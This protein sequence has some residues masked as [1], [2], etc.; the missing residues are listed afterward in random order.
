M[1]SH[2]LTTEIVDFK[3]GGDKVTINLTLGGSLTDEGGTVKINKPVPIEVEL[4]M[5]ERVENCEEADLTIDEAIAPGNRETPN[6]DP[7]VAR[8]V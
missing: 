7:R 1:K 4:Q 2:E 5:G 8:R 6:D 3:I